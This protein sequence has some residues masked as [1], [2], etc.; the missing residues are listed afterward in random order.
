MSHSFGTLEESVDWVNA[1]HW[2]IVLDN[3]EDDKV[4]TKRNP[5]AL[6]DA[7]ADVA[8]SI[9]QID[10][11][12]DD[13]GSL[14]DLYDRSN[15]T[16]TLLASMINLAGALRSQG[17]FEEAS[18]IDHEIA[19]L[20]KRAHGDAYQGD[21]EHAPCHSRRPVT[22][23]MNDGAPNAAIRNHKETSNRRPVPNQTPEALPSLGHTRLPGGHSKKE[24][25]AAT[26]FDSV[27]VLKRVL[28]H[29]HPS[30]LACSNNLAEALRGQGKY[31]EAEALHRK[32][33]S[34]K[35]MVYGHTHPSTL[36]SMNNLALV[37]DS[38]GRHE[39]AESIYREIIHYM[40]DLF[41]H[42]YDTI[43]FDPKPEQRNSALQF[44]EAGMSEYEESTKRGTVVAVESLSGAVKSAWLVIEAVP[45]DLPLKIAT[46]S[47]LERLTSA[48]AI[49]CSN[50][51][52][53][54]TREMV[55]NLCESTKRR[56]LNMHYY[57]P[58]SIRIIELM[59]SGNTDAAIFPF[60]V[61]K[62]RET[63]MDPYIARKESTGFIFN[64]LWAAVKREVLNILAEG[65]AAPEEVDRLWKTMLSGDK[66]GPVYSMDIIGLDTV[67]K[68]EQH[69]IE[70]RGLPD[71]PVKFLQGYIDQ[72]KLGLKSPY[73]G[74]LSPSNP[75]PASKKDD[76][77]NGKTHDPALYIVDIGLSTGTFPGL[78]Q[79]GRILVDFQDTKPLKSIVSSQRTPDGID[80]SESAA[81]LF[82]TSMGM[83][84][85]KDGA[86]YA[87]DLDGRNVTEIVSRGSIHTPKQLTVDKENHK[88]YFADREGL[89][90]MRCNFDG[91]DMEVLV[92]T[93]DSQN[94][95]YRADPMRWCVGV[96]VSP[97]TGKFYWT[98]KGPSKGNKGRIFTA[99]IAFAT[100]ETAETRTDMELLLQDLPEPIDLEIDQADNVLYWTDRGELPFGNSINRLK[101]DNAVKS[102]AP[103]WPGK[104]YELIAR[105]LH[106]AIGLKIDEK[107][108]RIYATDL[109]GSVY[110]MNMDGGQWKR[111]HEGSGSLAGITL[112]YL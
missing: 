39:E 79:A 80:I 54:K 3:A 17:R 45:E 100:G 53:Y 32:T 107:N 48:D 11:W 31:D 86:I 44:I 52:S 103:S 37:I 56:V 24:D 83:P 102:E 25:V 42:G 20:E 109:G 30:T 40:M 1:S 60:L 67:A 99:K 64:R 33:L 55:V 51:S 72:G 91:S 88:I 104:D 6:I 34:L 10:P 62:L 29:S 84:T 87:S 16:L 75:A 112:G 28:G 46:F 70:E 58:P 76:E 14:N 93:G 19:C 50:S 22:Q 18:E 36:A 66:P 13:S 97:S 2:R 106:E 82:W 94:E 95:E 69:Y 61:K 26:N 23:V 8:K 4:N 89:K 41:A 92:T 15:L 101:L 5:K 9:H 105:G 90:V 59:T 21:A 27:E 47:D 98:Q 63:S 49:L 38:Q 68:V 78:L 12:H 96:T 110:R 65:V 77:R 71:Q 111:L 35:R 43:I 74:L 73:G 108:R 85:D 81:K 57:M 7:D